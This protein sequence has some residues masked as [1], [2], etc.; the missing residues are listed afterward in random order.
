MNKWPTK[1]NTE[2]LLH[3][4]SFL[5]PKFMHT[6]KPVYTLEHSAILLTFTKLLFVIEIFVLSVLNGRLKQVLLYVI[7]LGWL[8]VCL[9]HVQ[10]PNSIMRPEGHLFTRCIL[11]FF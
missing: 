1:V 6:V 3:L 5:L 4:R 9:F 10:V 7:L 8:Y 2:L 11:Y